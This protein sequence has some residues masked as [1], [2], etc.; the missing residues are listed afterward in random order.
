MFQNCESK[1]FVQITIYLEELDKSDYGLNCFCFSQAAE[2]L[3]LLNQF[4][5]MGFQQN[6][7]KEVLLIHENHRERA[8]EELMTRLG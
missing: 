6:A 5:E 1:V 4:N 3:R 2:F 8:L 7:I